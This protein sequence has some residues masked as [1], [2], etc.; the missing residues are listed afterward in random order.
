MGTS[1]SPRRVSRGSALFRLGW[2]KETGCF[3]TD[4]SGTY[5]AQARV[6]GFMEMDET[7]AE[8]KVRREQEEKQKKRMEKS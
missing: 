3:F 7:G 8:Y 1:F 4:S 6:C 5:I 2:T